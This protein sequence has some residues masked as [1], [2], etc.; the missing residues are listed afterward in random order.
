M[1]ISSPG[2][3]GPGR[4]LAPLPTALMAGKARA[5]TVSETATV[6]GLLLAA[7]ANSQ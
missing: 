6:C 1:L 2:E 5:V 7:H 4:K 3:M